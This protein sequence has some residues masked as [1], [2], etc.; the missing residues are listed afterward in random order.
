MANDNTPPRIRLIVTVTVITVVTLIALKF[1]FDSYFAYMSD[2]ATHEKLAEPIARRNLA[3]IEK[4]HLTGSPLPIEAAMA[5]LARGARTDAELS[6]VEPKPSDDNGPL[7]GWSKLPKPLPTPHPRP[8]AT[9][10]EVA[11]DDAGAAMATAD[12]DAGAPTAHDAHDAGAAHAHTDPAPPMHTAAPI[13]PAP[14]PKPAPVA[15]TPAPTVA[16]PPA[17]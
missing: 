14:A 13:A 2:Q 16:P 8:A 1:V 9:L 10:G 4:K 15:P 12:G 3:E 17:P 7:I 5:K 6:D 11:T